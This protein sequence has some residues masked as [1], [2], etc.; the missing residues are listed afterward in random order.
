MKKII[1]SSLLLI[2]LAVSAVSCGGKKEESTTYKIGFI[3][4]LTGATSMYG[5]AVMNG[6]EAVYHLGTF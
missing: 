1:I 4:P 6:A 5:N 3:G 2:F